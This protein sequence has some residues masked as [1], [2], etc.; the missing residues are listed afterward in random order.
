MMKDVP[1]EPNR[2]T[3]AGRVLLEGKAI[4]IPD[5]QLDADYDWP[6]ARELAGFRTILGV[7]LLR[8]GA[9][10]G[11]L[12]L[13][14]PEVRPFTD[15]QIELLTTF[16]DQAV[17]AIE[18]VRLFD[19]IQDKNRQLQIVSENKSQFVSSMS[20]ELRTPL[21]AII[22]LTEMMVTNAARFGT[23][24]AQEPL[25]RVNRAGT[26]LLGLINQVLD[27]SKIEA[28]K[29]ELN[30]QTVQLAP[31]INEVI[32]T[33]RQ[34]AEQNKNQLAGD[35]PADLGT[36]TVDPMRLRQILLNLLSNAC[37]FTKEG[38]VKLKARRVTAGI[39]LT[40]VDSGIGMTA[41][42]QAKLFG[43]FSQADATTAQRFGG[44][45]LGLAITRKLARM[46]GGDVTVTSEPGKGSVFTVRLPAGAN[47]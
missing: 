14:R 2:R 16:A 15:K 3:L 37:K 33:A 45:G 32:G 10:I 30:P 44:T 7:P 28:G 17:I 6:E 1:V 41:E 22:G 42:Q 34:L 25:Q 47:T 29:L 13:S 11:V 35:T 12:A 9:P 19:E 27:L 40:V 18:N 43:E 39:E 26:H 23:D 38:E 21:N 31:L 8:E 24:K 5:V 4:H 46:M 20:H 36:L